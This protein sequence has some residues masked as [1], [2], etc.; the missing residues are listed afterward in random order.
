[1]GQSPKKR[2]SLERKE[3]STGLIVLKILLWILL[4]ILGIVLLVLIL[5]V[6]AK[7]SFIGG[8]FSYSVKFAFLPMLNSNKKGIVDFILKIKN[9]KKKKESDDETDIPPEEAADSDVT[10]SESQ[11]TTQ[12]KQEE[13]IIHDNDEKTD[14]SPNVTAEVDDAE[15]KD[16]GDLDDFDDIEDDDITEEETK[17]KF[18]IDF[19]LDVWE[20][21]DRPLLKIFKGIKLS[22]LYIDFA[23]ANEDAYKC[24]LNYGRISGAL[25]QLLGWL[26]VLFNVKLKTVDIIPAFAM[27]KSRFDASA[28]VSFCLI[29]PLIAG[30]WFLI[31]YLFKVFIPSR[32]KKRS[33]VK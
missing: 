11:N 16:L 2:Q 9:K 4:V 31:I 3:L 20:A 22:E 12:N 6:S 28:K 14:E 25:Y 27:K 26:S 8:K 18:D 10:E 23:I 15:I 17:K 5:P 1:M 19:I 30:I 7:A 13:N 29:T 32:K 33:E 24:A 21:A